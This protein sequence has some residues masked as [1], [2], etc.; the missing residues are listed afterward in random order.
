MDNPPFID[1]L[2]IFS[3]H[4]NLVSGFPMISQ[5][6]TRQRLVFSRRLRIPRIQLCFPCGKFLSLSFTTMCPPSW[7]QNLHFYVCLTVHDSSCSDQI[8]VLNIILKW[9][10]IPHL[11]DDLPIKGPLFS[12]I[13]HCRKAFP[14]EPV[15]VGD[16]SPVSSL[17][18]QDVESKNRPIPVLAI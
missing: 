1:H 14:A 6:A 2:S 17:N 13:F 10:L 16:L 18:P 11:I 12:G 9:I 8:I 15:I 3:F 5:L 7:N 4:F